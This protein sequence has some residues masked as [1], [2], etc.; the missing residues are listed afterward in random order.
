MHTY[1]DTNWLN[2]MFYKHIVKSDGK[3]IQRNTAFVT[4][5]IIYIVINYAICF[6]ILATTRDCGGTL[7]CVRSYFTC[8]IHSATM[9]IHVECVNS[10]EQM[11]NIMYILIFTS[12][13]RVP[14]KRIYHSNTLQKQT[15]YYGKKWYDHNLNQH[16]RCSQQQTYKNIAHQI[17]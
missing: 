9:H 6:C 16:T 11:I 13:Q 2:S 4:Y 12:I 3:R 14:V 10:T 15:W 7:L 1:A 5:R 8:S 17:H